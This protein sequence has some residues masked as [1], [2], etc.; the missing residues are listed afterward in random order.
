MIIPFQN[1]LFLKEFL[2][3]NGF[4]GLFTKVKKGSGNSLWYTF[5]AW[6]S[7]KNVPYLILYQ[8]IKF[9]CHTFFPS[10]DIKPNV[11]LSS[12]LDSWW[13]HKLYDLSWI[14][15]SSNGWEGEKEGKVEIQKFENLQ[16]EKSL[17]DE[18]KNMFHSFWRPIIWW[19][20]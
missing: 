1:I 2:A 17:F 20:I 9:Q 11:L 7:N 19:K 16:K 5:S 8:W 18:I 13:H 14:N 10:Q 15:L 3:C 6:F 4:F 12:Y